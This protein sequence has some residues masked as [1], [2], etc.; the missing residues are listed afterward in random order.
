M[1]GGIQCSQGII[2]IDLDTLT[3]HKFPISDRSYSGQIEMVQAMP[4]YYP[5]GWGRERPPCNSLNFPPSL[6]LA[7]IVGG[8]VDREEV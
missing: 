6:S 2:L 4:F 3:Q 8:Q 1:E 7:L 5:G